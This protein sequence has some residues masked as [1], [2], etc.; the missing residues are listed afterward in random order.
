MSRRNRQNVNVRGKKDV[1]PIM[2]QLQNV[3]VRTLTLEVKHW[4]AAVAGSQTQSLL[5]L[6]C[7]AGCS[8]ACD[9]YVSGINS[10][11][12]PVSGP[13]KMMSADIGSRSLAICTG[14]YFGV[15][16]PVFF[17]FS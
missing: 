10:S 16:I 13:V 6:K 8:I 9:D 17:D 7:E 14:D 2:K 15:T 3:A 4:G 12:S 5:N 1:S 11:I